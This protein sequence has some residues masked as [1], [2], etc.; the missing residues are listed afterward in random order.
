MSFNIGG[1]RFEN[2]TGQVV[3]VR[4]L[5]TQTCMGIRFLKISRQEERIIDKYIMD[6]QRKLIKAYKVGET[7]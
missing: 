2:L 4:V 7:G 6:E 1:H 3:N 5:Q